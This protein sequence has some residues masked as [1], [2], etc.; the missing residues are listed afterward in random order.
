MSIISE[1]FDASAASILDNKHLEAHIEQIAK[2][3][4]AS[5]ENGGKLLICGNGG[6][7]AD[8][9]HLS[10]ELLNRYKRERR[11]LPG[12]TLTADGSTITSIGNDYDYSEVFSK[13]VSA[14]GKAGDC[15]MVITT[16]GN[17][18]N[19]IKAVQ[20]AHEKSVT[21]I[22][23]NGKNGGQYENTTGGKLFGGDVAVA[24]TFSSGGAL[25]MDLSLKNAAIVDATSS[26]AGIRPISGYFDMTQ[27]ITG[28]GTSQDA[29]ISSLNGTGAVTASEGIINGINIPELSER[30]N[31]LSNQNGLLRLLSS[32]LSG[33][34]TPYEGGSSAITT[35]NGFIQLSPFDVNMLGAQSAVDLGINLAQWKMNLDGEMSLSDHPGAPPIGISVLGDLHNPEIAYNTKQ[36]EG[37]IGQKIAASLLQNMVEG[38]GGLGGLFG[39]A[40]GQDTTSSD[41][42]TTV[43]ATEGPTGTPAST[44]PVSASPLEDFIEPST[45]Q[46]P[47]QAPQNPAPA[48]TQEQQQESVE[49]LGAKL[50]E[51]LFK[52]PPPQN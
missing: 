41:G 40:G 50:L 45:T 36:L 20:V 13:Q 16:S 2:T 35:K 42:A 1:H 34:E 6:S 39:G 23:L 27:K 37:F 44:E 30:L 17:S 25:D 43:P 24:G 21:V 48:P 49:E 7:A 4:Y 47:N 31:G 28:N 10:S 3:L 5:F 52:K 33:G 29:L 18:A 32:S 14:L 8:A 11:E 12:I 22:A 9:Q 46:Q 19:L 15:L 51:R 38:N 26:F